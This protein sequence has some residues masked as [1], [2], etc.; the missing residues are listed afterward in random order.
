MDK[1]EGAQANRKSKIAAWL[2][3]AWVLLLMLGMIIL[4]ALA[5]SGAGGKKEAPTEMPPISDYT[6][7]GVP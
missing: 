6:T 1:N 5:I 4:I 2:M 3:T 7:T